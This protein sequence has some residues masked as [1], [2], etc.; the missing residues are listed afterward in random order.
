MWK[1]LASN[2]ICGGQRPSLI[3][4]F[5]AKFKK[6]TASRCDNFIIWTRIVVIFRKHK[7][8]ALLVELWSQI[9]YFLTDC[10]R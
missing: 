10:R 2:I 6:R 8:E 1:W 9:L 4:N 7:A 3:Q 5:F